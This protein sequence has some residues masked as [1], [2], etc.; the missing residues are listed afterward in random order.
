MDFNFVMQNTRARDRMV[1][2]LR[3][4]QIDDGS[5]VISAFISKARRQ[6]ITSHVG[7][8]RAVMIT[9]TDS[10]DLTADHKP[11]NPSEKERV[12]LE[13][14]RIIQYGVLRVQGIL[15]VTR[16]LGDYC[17]RPYVSNIPT[18]NYFELKGKECFLILASDGLW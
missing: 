1:F 18:V 3:V 4:R 6:V 9:E 15:A 2:H 11:S 13:G 8:S 17:L 14:G 5:T 16:A 10:F 7:D 12:E